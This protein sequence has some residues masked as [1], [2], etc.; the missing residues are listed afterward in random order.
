MTVPVELVNVTL[1]VQDAAV[2]ADEAAAA[3]SKLT[4][5]VSVDPKPTEPKIKL[6][7]RTVVVVWPDAAVAAMV[8]IAAARTEIRRF[9]DISLVEVNAAEVSPIGFRRPVIFRS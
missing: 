8:N 5:I 4:C 7:V 1:P 9:M 3:F 2:P 6:R